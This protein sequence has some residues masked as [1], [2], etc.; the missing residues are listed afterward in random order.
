VAGR[1]YAVAWK[2]LRLFMKEILAEVRT[3][4]VRREDSFRRLPPVLSTGP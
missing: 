4:N 1:Y 3:L 2:S